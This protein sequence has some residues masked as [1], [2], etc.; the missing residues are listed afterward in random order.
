MRLNKA[1][2]TE[3]DTP[4]TSFF[5]WLYVMTLKCFRYRN[6]TIKLFSIK[7]SQDE[8]KKIN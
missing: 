4:Y 6:V 7:I 8:S 5:I 3:Y 1:A 2:E